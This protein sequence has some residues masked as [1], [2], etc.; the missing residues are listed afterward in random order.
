[1]EIDDDVQLVK[2]YSSQN[3]VVFR[4]DSQ[5]DSNRDTQLNYDQTVF[6]SCQSQKTNLYRQME[7]LDISI[8]KMVLI[9]SILHLI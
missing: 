7:M 6:F 8:V 9:P 4:G 2:D 5:F 1:L 3:N